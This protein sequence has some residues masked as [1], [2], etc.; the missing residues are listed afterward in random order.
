VVTVSNDSQDKAVEKRSLRLEQ[1]G[2]L[3]LRNGELV[4]VEATLSRPAYVYLVW[5]DSNG[6]T[7]P[8]YPWNAET[9]A[10]GWDAPLL[11]GSRRAVTTLQLPRSANRGF[12]AVGAPGMQ[13]VVLLA[14]D[15]PL[16]IPAT[17]REQ[18]GQLPPSPL[19][20][21]RELSY[22]EWSAGDGASLGKLRGVAGGVTKEIRAFTPTLNLIRERLRDE[23]Q[24]IKVVRFA[25]VTE[26][27]KAESR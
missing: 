23:F 20:D 21:A 13:H 18:L 22:L 24:F 12:E 17:L 27:D 25:Q 16:A 6:Q 10:A 26:D 15:A 11:S 9:S 3:P 4:R 14:R 7:T 2:A 1:K 5:I 8:L 19:T